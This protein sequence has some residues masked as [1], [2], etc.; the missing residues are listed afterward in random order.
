MESRK[1][2]SHHSSNRSSKSP[3]KKS[4]KQMKEEIKE[5]IEKSDNTTSTEEK[6][7]RKNSF[8]IRCCYVCCKLD[9][10]I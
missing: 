3:I 10:M 1:Y 4:K 6:V 9:F 8:W 2:S 5:E 7:K